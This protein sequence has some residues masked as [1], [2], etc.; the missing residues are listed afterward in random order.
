MNIQESMKIIDELIFEQTGR[1]LDTLQL[2]ILKNVINGQNYSQI[3]QEYNCSKGHARDKAYEL[4]H[5][6]SET[7]GEDLN[8]SNVRSAIER[9]IISTGNHNLINSGQIDRVNLCPNS[10]QFTENSELNNSDDIQIENLLIEE[11]LKEAKLGTVSKLVQLG[12]T[13]K[14]I[15]EAL[16]LELSLILQTLK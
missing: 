4:W 13:E 10:S 5:I 2:G 1:H 11:K 8:K 9:L 3:A 16:D 6:L 7:L 12:L 14:Q 15:A